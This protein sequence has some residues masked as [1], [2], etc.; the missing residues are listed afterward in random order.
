MR[1]YFLLTR[2]LLKSGLGGFEASGKG[3]K[4]RKAKIGQ[5]AIWLFLLVCLLPLMAVVFHIGGEAY[6]ML[7]PI[8]QEG[9]A[10]ELIFF[11]SALLSLILGFPM[12]ISVFYM[13]NDVEKLLYLPVHSWQIVGAK[14][15]IAL[16]YTYL[17]S[18]YLLLPFLLGFGIRAGSGPLYWIFTVFAIFLL[19]VVPL[20]YGGIISLVIMRIFKRAKNKDF[21]TVLSVTA[22][23]ILAVGISSVSSNLDM[24]GEALMALLMKGHNSL[25]GLMNGIFPELRFIAKAIA[26]GS[27]VSFLIFLAVTVLAVVVFFLIAEKLYFAGAMGMRETTAKRKRLSSSD[28]KALGRKQS[29]LMAY[30]KKEIRLLLRTPMYF[31]NCVMMIFLWPVLLLIPF[32]LQLGQGGLSLGEM[33]RKIDLS[34]GTASAI[35]VFVIFCFSLISGM[36]CY[37]AGTAISREGKGFYFMKLIPVPVKTQLRAKLLSALFFTILGTTGYSVI[38]LAI[39]IVLFGLPV[40]S[41]P[42]VVVA[43]IMVNVIENVIQFF[44]D[45]FH[46]KLS[47][48]SEQQ[49]VKQNMTVVLGMFLCMAAGIGLG[50]LVF[51]LYGVLGLSAPVYGM[52]VCVFLAALAFLLYQGVLAYGVRRIGQIDG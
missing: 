38:L 37:V 18:V 29:A 7:A 44:V 28:R 51:W 49:A 48:E 50:V 20:V 39:G 9:I 27:I 3:K 2:K 43:S 35:A 46:P 16:L 5:G 25:M 40:W 8:G 30:T 15:T 4:K 10:L 21:L 45:L 36:F 26:E 14:F 41:L 34:G 31:M 19:P 47:W 11:V 22:S 42:V 52:I 24:E 1:K 12:V 33:I 23:L 32:V 17:S 13:T 6:S